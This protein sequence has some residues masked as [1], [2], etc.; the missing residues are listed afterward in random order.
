MI[1]TVKKLPQCRGKADLWEAN[2][3]EA[4]AAS[5]GSSVVSE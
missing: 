1:E 2:V 4:A 5:G 3:V